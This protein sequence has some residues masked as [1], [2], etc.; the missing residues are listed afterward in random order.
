MALLDVGRL[1]RWWKSEL[2]GLLPA[3]DV[4]RAAS[5][6]VTV[7]L[8]AGSLQAGL[9]R[10]PRLARAL[11]SPPSAASIDEVIDKLRSGDRVA[12]TVD[13]SHCFVRTRAIPQAVL[14]D[15]GQILALDLAR[16]MPFA[17]ASI[18]SGWY[19]AGKPEK[20]GLQPVAQ[21]I[22]RR[23]IIDPVLEAIR[24]RR[25]RPVAI[26]IRQGA[27]PARPF[28][29]AIDGAPF[30]ADRQRRW[31]RRLGIGSA[32]A[33]LMLLA[34]GYAGLSRQQETLRLLDA[35]IESLQGPTREV[36]LAL[37]AKTGARA[38]QAELQRLRQQ[39]LP[40]L[41][42]WEELSRLLPDDAWVQTLVSE[43]SAVQIE[44]VAHAAEELI[45]LLEASPLFRDVQFTSPVFKAAESNAVRFSVR[46]GIEERT[47]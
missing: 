9:Y 33:M 25:A 40:G 8:H 35:E 42:I 34:A 17:P 13:E 16:S 32:T 10:R 47:P 2:K 24:A 15:A 30:G 26:A 19:K 31:R 11:P 41:A 23:D 38:Q 36:R 18:L 14:A 27:G 22:L 43:T 3:G 44:G 7:E 20:G 6:A 37:D 5:R 4:R 29:C 39:Q 1:W 28:V 21:V 12:L 45:P 46:L